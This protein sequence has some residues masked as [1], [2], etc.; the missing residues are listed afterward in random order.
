MHAPIHPNILFDYVVMIVGAM[1]GLS[2]HYD[3]NNDIIIT[4]HN[5]DNNDNDTWIYKP[6]VVC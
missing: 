4:N 6:T 2:C 3:N 5:D 1:L